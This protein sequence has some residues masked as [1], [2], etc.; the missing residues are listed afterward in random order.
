MFHL[1]GL[2]GYDHYRF[3]TSICWLAKSRKK[4]NHFHLGFHFLEPN[5]L[6]SISIFK[7]FR[8]TQEAF[9]VHLFSLL[10]LYLQLPNGSFILY[11]TNRSLQ[12][13]PILLPL[14]PSLP[15]PH[16]HLKNSYHSSSPSSCVSFSAKL[17]SPTR[18]QFLLWLTL[19]IES[20][21][22]S[23]AIVLIS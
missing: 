9:I 1:W 20:S 17:P 15:F 8:R 16:P 10:C 2:S 6:K 11:H 13:L 21:H 7:S 4:R 19:Y 23:K 18:A 3:L 5:R 12:M 22:F 14:P